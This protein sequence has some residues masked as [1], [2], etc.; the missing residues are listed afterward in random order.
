MKNKENIAADLFE[1][2]LSLQNEA[3]ELQGR[4]LTIYNTAGKLKAMALVIA[5]TLNTPLEEVV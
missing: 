4:I 5:Q 1:A 3:R 2:A